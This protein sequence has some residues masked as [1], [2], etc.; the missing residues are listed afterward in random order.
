MVKVQ[1]PVSSLSASGGLGKT[2]IFSTNRGQAYVKRW[3]A[4]ANPRTNL[5][6][7][8]R[9]ITRWCSSQWAGLL[10]ASKTTWETAPG[11]A[12]TS[13]FNAF[14]AENLRRWPDLLFPSSVYPPTEAASFYTSPQINA[15]AQGR[16]AEFLFYGGA[17]GQNWGFAIFEVA[18]AVAFRTW[19]DLVRCSFASGSPPWT[20]WIGPLDPG[21][22]YFRILQFSLDGQHPIG[23]AG[24]L[25]TVT[26]A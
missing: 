2:V 10:A 11:A 7:S 20:D 9:A 19:S 23:N 22:H 26:I 12:S 3:A 16:R 17:P 6:T 15:A 18:T 25:R 1:G 14:V 21:I 5:Q 13:P 8:L 24:R 4:P